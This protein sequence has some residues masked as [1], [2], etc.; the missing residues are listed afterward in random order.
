MKKIII[1]VFLLFSIIAE[2][3]D[4]KFNFEGQVRIRYEI[5]NDYYAKETQKPTEDYFLIRTRLGFNLKGKNWGIYLMGQQAEDMNGRELN[6]NMQPVEQDFDM[7][8]QQLYFY[9][10]KPANLPISIWIG[11]REVIYDR[12]ALIG[13]SIGWG[14]YVRSYDG[15]MI[16]LDL[17]ILK[18]DCFYMQNRK[19]DKEDLDDWFNNPHF[20]GYWFTYKNFSLFKIDQYFLVK[21]IKHS[22]D[23]VYTLGLRFYQ[24]EAKLYDFD[25]SSVYQFGNATENGNRTHRSAFAIHAELGYKLKKQR[26]GIEYNYA[27]GDDDPGSGHYSTFD[28]LYGC[29]HGKY[30]LMDFFTW[31]NM[32]ELQFNYNISPKKEIKLRTM[33]HCF[34]LA[35]SKDA[36]YDFTGK[37]IRKAT[38]GQDISNYVGTEWDFLYVHKLNKYFK[39]LAFYGHFFAGDYIRD[40]ATS[41]KAKDADYG[42]LE[43]RFN[44]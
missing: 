20:F 11:R 38:I 17:P 13:T 25:I 31:K 22:K 7:D 29:D 12:E 39:L 33:I 42:Y 18:L 1:A 5:K 30:G 8:F 15:G 14:N 35:T 3:K 10:E 36:W 9:L 26:I 24:K 32:H 27:S 40:T 19:P 34:W 28:K 37:V 21:D 2:A 41:K 4:L 44:W 23:I 16:S 6:L 43:L